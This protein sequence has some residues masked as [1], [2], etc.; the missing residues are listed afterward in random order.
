MIVIFNTIIVIVN[1]LEVIVINY[2]MII[3]TPTIINVEIA[4][5]IIIEVVVVK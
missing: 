4:S 5:T 2:Y 3:F 1:Y